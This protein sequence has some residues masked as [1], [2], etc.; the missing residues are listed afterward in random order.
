M[1]LR[2]WTI[3][4]G[5]FF[6][7]VTGYTVGPDMRGVVAEIE[8]KPIAICG[9]N[10]WTP[11]SV[12]MHIWIGDTQALKEGVFL[13]ECFRYVFGVC[14]KKMVVVTVPQDNEAC[15]KFIEWIGFS[16]IGRIV[17][18]WDDGVD[19]VAYQILRDKCKWFTS[20]DS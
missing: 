16:E 4:D 8:G 10:T 3:E 5:P 15:L 2:A 20:R 11:N 6:E 13:R 19:L 17:D 18:G 12:S 1:E 14:D 7:Q 9:C